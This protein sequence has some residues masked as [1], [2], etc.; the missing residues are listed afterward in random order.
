[1]VNSINYTPYNLKSCYSP[2]FQ[3]IDTGNK[4]NKTSYTE[5]D[6]TAMS[7]GTK[8]LVGIGLTA[9]AATGIYI[10]TKGRKKVRL[11]PGQEARINE[12]VTN[13][14]IN[15]KSA[16]IFKSVEGLG[17]DN[18]IKTLYKKFANA[19][20][21]DIY[22]R[23]KI[24]SLGSTSFSSHGKYIVI[25]KRSVRSKEELVDQIRHELEHFRQD[26]LIYRAFGKETWLDAL[27]DSSIN[28]LK[29]NEESCIRKFGKKFSEL[30]ET[31]IAQFKKSS[32]ELYDN[33]EHT[34]LFETL[35]E[36]KGRISPGTKEYEEATKLLE[37]TRTY[38]SPS[39]LVDEPLTKELIKKLRA[40]NPEKYKLMQEI[41]K[42]YYNNPL[43]IGAN[44]KGHNLR[45]QYK[46]FKEALNN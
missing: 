1:M 30:S 14:K 8:W 44:T 32:K 36:L 22:P 18:L 17:G 4:L 25:D 31:E 35:L 11:T 46:L 23:L 38:V 26:D 40:E 3:G 33:N 29:Y 37:A 9:L 12:L 24:T 43:E 39:M 2:K 21:Y 20:G 19:M 41:G 6:K 42:Q 13:G 27:A 10:A 34:E 28:R 7:T 15:E 5:K 45:E 16:E